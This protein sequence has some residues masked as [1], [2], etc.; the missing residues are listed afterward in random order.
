MRV[1]LLTDAGDGFTTDPECVEAAKVAAQAL[2]AWGCEVV[3]VGPEVLL[4]EASRVN[5]QTWM[6]AITRRV[7]A[8][9]AILGRPLTED[10]VD[11]YNWVAA[12]RGR[13]VT[14]AEA[15]AAAEGQQA[16]V[17]DVFAWMQPFDLLVTPT[18][19]CPPLTTAQAQ[20]DPDKPWRIG[21]TYGLVGRF[22]LPFNVT[23]HPAIS[24]PLHRTSE[25][26]PV[27]SQLVGRMGAEGTLL[28]LAARFEAEMPWAHLKP[29]V[30]AGD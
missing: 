15:A 11:P 19:G 21:R 18:S 24:L 9:G 16:W 29:A 17:R 6:A 10:E 8:L 28:R 13:S 7:D 25:G 5:G 30:W 12:Q 27:G 26:L 4:G 23:G 3:E 20:P 1:A 2:Q 14:A 22:T